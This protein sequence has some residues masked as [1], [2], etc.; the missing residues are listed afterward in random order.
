M[1]SSS[2]DDSPHRRD[3]PQNDDDV[4][5]SLMGLFA[6]PP[7]VLSSTDE[8]PAPNVDDQQDDVTMEQQPQ[9][10]PVASVDSAAADNATQEATATEAAP[11]KESGA[12]TFQSL[13]EPPRSPRARHERSESENTPLLSSTGSFGNDTPTPKITQVSRKG[14]PPGAAARTKEATT[15]MPSYYSKPLP[16]IEESDKNP[17]TKAQLPS[18][19]ETVD[20]C[21]TT[22]RV[23]IEESSKTS[24]WIG[25]VLCLL[26]HN[27]F[28]LTM[29]SAI[30]GTHRSVS[31]L[32][33]F[34]KMAA[35]GVLTGAPVYW[36]NLKG[37]SEIPA[38]Y[39]T[40]DL[41]TAPFLAAIA[42]LVD[43]AL[44]DDPNVGED[45][46]QI[47]LASFT[48]LACLAVFL[49]GGFMVFA[50][51]F[52]LANLGS[53]LPF[54]VLAGFFA[55]V[56][57]L[58]WTLAFKID[59]QMPI[60][61]VLF[62]GDWNVVKYALFHH[63]PSLTIAALMKILGPKSPFYVI[64][65]VMS[66]I[67]LFYLAMF[68]AGVSM[69]A[70]TQDKWFWSQSDLVYDNMNAKIGFSQFAPP[71]PFG[72][73][74]SLWLGQVHWGAV[75]SGLQPTLA[76]SFLYLIRCSIH[77]AAL[78][79][80][81][82]TLRRTETVV[83]GDDDSSGGR[84]SL[85]TRRPSARSGPHSRAFSEVLDLERV[86]GASQSLDPGATEATVQEVGPMPT[87]LSLKEIMLEYGHCQLVCGLVGC[88]AVVPSVAASQTFYLVRFDV[89]EYFDR[90]ASRTHLD[91]FLDNKASCREYG[92]SSGI[93]HSFILFLLD[94][95]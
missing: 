15:F 21:K 6:P 41:F 86:L 68:V 67:A 51:V 23:I 55:A 25:A 82:T 92:S 48:F 38:L 12:T 95:L 88:F 45:D 81:L 47:F 20:A 78:K 53:F 5:T 74:N 71:A 73:F 4:T 18:V 79:K 52:K 49:A 42:V 70:A 87:T 94:R 76:L 39:P 54:P 10:N 61:Q 17:A 22:M 14:T 24:T 19:K 30:T 57:V 85:G 11:A 1:S 3:G 33:L 43:D 34:T 60:G 65:L 40:V 31:M 77:S 16:I 56:G 36:I 32:G 37:S 8:D 58:M 35:L 63:V 69:E 80:N 89:V 46:D 50:S 66:S 90:L 29:G 13:F 91:V 2:F 72:L 75:A 44:H 26:Y 83:S 28:C 7:P 59:T 64:G 27:V 93:N 9:K 84:P 62:S